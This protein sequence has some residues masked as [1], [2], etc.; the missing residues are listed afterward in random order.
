[1]EKER[2]Q[3]GESQNMQERRAIVISGDIYLPHSPMLCIQLSEEHRDLVRDTQNETR[4]TFSLSRYMLGK[5]H[6]I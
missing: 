5:I 4:L 1:M 2:C 3:R 6:H